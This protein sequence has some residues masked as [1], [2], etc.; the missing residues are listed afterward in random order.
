MRS[1]LL[2][3]L[4]F[5]VVFVRAQQGGAPPVRT[6]EP[7]KGGEQVTRPT[8]T[9][10]VATGPGEVIIHQEERIGRLMDD[11]AARKH[12]LK[13]YRVQIFMGGNREAGKQVRIDFLRKH[14][15]VPAYED[16][17]APNFRVRVGDMR[18]RMEAARLLR[19]L[20]ADYPGAYIVP[21]EIEM[22]RLPE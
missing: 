7:F 10:E 9:P 16:Y 14:T 3:V 5:H 4:V 20:K 8:D 18:T 11:F 21:D 6:F 13:G 22:P 2:P 17:L 12:T 15:E 19:E 1:F